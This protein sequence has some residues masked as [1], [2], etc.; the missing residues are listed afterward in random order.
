MTRRVQGADSALAIHQRPVVRAGRPCNP[1][2]TT[3][4][5]LRDAASE[6]L[7]LQQ[8][9][10]APPAPA[11][12]S[13]GRVV[14]THGVRISVV[15]P[16]YNRLTWVREAVASACMQRAV[17]CEI[18]VVDDGSSDGTAATLRHEYGARIRVIE[19]PNRG[20][21]AARN[22]GVAA[23]SAELIAFLDSDDL[24]MRDKLAA[25]AS[26]FVSHTD[27]E[28]CQTQEIWMRSGVRVNPCAHHRKPSGDIFECSLRR[29]LVSPSA[30]LLRRS[31]FERVGGF[32]ESLPACED[33]DLWL[34]ILRDTPVWL[35]DRPLV[36]KRGGHDDQLSR[37]FWG[38][39]R[40]RVAALLR[41]L[42]EDNLPPLRRAATRRV[43]AEKCA[44][45][46]KGAARRGRHDEA[47][48]Y[49]MLAGVYQQATVGEAHPAHR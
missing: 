8:R 1:S 41:L 21:A 45:L 46:A 39:D 43:L 34:R 47:D 11:L 13:A 15:I 42:S 31:L 17:T 30:V 40:F 33:Y 37:R 29:C 12:S 5:E 6:F 10:P 26:Y 27:A 3:A 14:S 9:E 48:R 49:R 19:T 38:M 16:T 18:I 28:I 23:S 25:Q 24:W 32:D 2:P 44:V 20:V 4:A 22:L 7:P 36:I 35:I